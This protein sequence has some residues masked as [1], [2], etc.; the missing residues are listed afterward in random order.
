MVVEV[1]PDCGHHWQ[2]VAVVIH[3]RST[4]TCPEC[5]A[6]WRPHVLL[7][8]RRKL[9]ATAAGNGAALAKFR[10][11]GMANECEALQAGLASMIA[12]YDQALATLPAGSLARRLVEGAFGSAPGIARTLI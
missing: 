9:A 11:L 10:R 3:G 2:Q 7:A 1:C 6:E 5:G 4:K 8:H 12:G